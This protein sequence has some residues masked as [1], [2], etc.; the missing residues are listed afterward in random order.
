MHSSYETVFQEIPKKSDNLKIG[1]ILIPPA[2]RR[3]GRHKG[4]VVKIYS[5][6]NGKEIKSL[7]VFYV[8]STYF[9]IF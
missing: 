2:K 8:K 6:K 4:W 1:K 7:T 9:P 5:V 3:C